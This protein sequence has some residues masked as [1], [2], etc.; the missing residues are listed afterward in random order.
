MPW[1]MVTCKMQIKA[2]QVCYWDDD[3][4]DQLEL[5]HRVKAYPPCIKLTLELLGSQPTPPLSLLFTFSG[6]TADMDMEIMF[7]LGILYVVPWL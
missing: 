6:S 3:K 2:S 4:R 5:L 7:P 1:A